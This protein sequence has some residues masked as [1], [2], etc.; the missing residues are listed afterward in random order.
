MRVYGKTGTADSIGIKDEILC[1]VETATSAA[2][3]RG[4]SRIGEPADA[5]LCEPTNPRRIAVAVVIP[6]SATGAASPVRPRWRSWPRRRPTGYFRP[7]RDADLP[8][9]VPGM[10]APPRRARRRAAGRLALAR[11]GAVPSPVPCGCRGSRGAAP[12]ALAAGAARCPRSP[13]PRCRRRRR[14]RPGRD[15][16]PPT[17]PR[18]PAAAARPERRRRRPPTGR[19]GAESRRSRR[20]LGGRGPL[21]EGGWARSTACTPRSPIA[22]SAALKILKTTP[23]PRRASASSARRSPERARPSRH[24]P[25]HGLRRGSGARASLSRHGARGG[26]DAQGRLQRG[27]SAR[28]EAVNRLRAPGLRPGARARRRHPSTAT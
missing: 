2:R 21:G 27:P 12:A 26:R 8:A 15:A 18:D 23:T 11:D 19:E 1:G 25:R 17:T 16:R 22:C 20:R 3:I 14:G 10:T 4:S 7:R 9:P 13:R 6:R 5:T 24:R 28:A